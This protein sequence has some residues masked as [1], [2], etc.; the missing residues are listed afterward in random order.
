[1]NQGPNTPWRPNNSTNTSPATT[2]DT[3]NGRSMSVMSS[4]L[5]R[6]SNL[7]M[8]QAAAR[9]K[10]RF[11]ATEMTATSSVR[12]MADSASGSVSDLR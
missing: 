1:M 7:A 3:A 11:S 2:G 8:A 4:V 9:P 12:R 5:P 10:T 6:N